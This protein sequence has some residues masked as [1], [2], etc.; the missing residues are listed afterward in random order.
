[1]AAK[2]STARPRAAK[3]TDKSENGSIKAKVAE[4]E[5]QQ[6]ELENR[7][8]E[9]LKGMIDEKEAEVREAREAVRAAQAQLAA[10]EKEMLDF[11]VEAGVISPAQAKSKVVRRSSGKA[12]KK[13]TDVGTKK[14]YLVGLLEKQ[15]GK[16]PMPWSNLKAVLKDSGIFSQ[17]DFNSAKTFADKYLPEG[18][19]LEGTRFDAQF[20]KA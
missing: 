8:K 10:K 3:T 12:R 18:W 1:M 13:R 7:K 11:K 15:S 20:V 6:K 19:K 4:I 16:G 5:S 14:E 17:A 2:S 9:L